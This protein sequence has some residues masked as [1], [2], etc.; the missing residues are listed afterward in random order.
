MFYRSR[1]RHF[2]INNKV[3]DGIVCDMNAEIKVVAF[4]EEVDRLYNLM[5]LNQVRLWKDF[6]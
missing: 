3:F 5:N 6:F 2:G 4:N 1:I